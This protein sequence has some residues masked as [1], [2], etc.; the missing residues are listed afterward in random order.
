MQNRR[1]KNK[2]SKGVKYFHPTEKLHSLAFNI[3]LTVPQIPRAYI[4]TNQSKWLQGSL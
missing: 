2:F 4:Q 3:R 1:K